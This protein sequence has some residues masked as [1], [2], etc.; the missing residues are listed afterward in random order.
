MAESPRSAVVPIADAN[1]GEET[2]HGSFHD[3]STHLV[4]DSDEM[5]EAFKADHLRA[6]QALKVGQATQQRVYNKGRLTLEFQTGD[7]VLLN[8]H[9]LEMLR[10]GKGRGRR[11]LIRYDGPFEVMAKISPVTYPSF[12]QNPPYHQY[13]SSRALQILSSG[14]RTKANTTPAT[15]QLEGASRDGSRKHSSRKLEKEPESWSTDHPVSDEICWA[16]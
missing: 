5:A 15:C 16:R 2:P 9:S 3:S 13:C 11:L 4:A 8:P 12:V 14:I 1:L 7:L 10:A 6:Q